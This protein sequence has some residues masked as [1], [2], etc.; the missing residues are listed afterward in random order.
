MLSRHP[1]AISLKRSFHMLIIFVLLSLVFAQAYADTTIHINPL[2]IQ[3]GTFMVPLRSLCDQ[4]G[5]AIAW[6]NDTQMAIVGN[7]VLETRYALGLGEDLVQLVDNRLYIA[8]DYFATQQELIYVIEQD[9][10]LAFYQLDQVNIDQMMQN[11]EHIASLP[12]PEKS[13]ELERVRKYLVEELTSMG[14]EVGLQP[15]ISPFIMALPPEHPL[16]NPNIDPEVG[17]NIIATKTAL[18]NLEE[19]PILL[20]TA[21]YNS[22]PNSPSANQKGSGVVGLLE[23]AKLMQVVSSNVELRMVFFDAELNTGLG[24]F[25]YV[26]SLTDSEVE[27]IIAV[28]D[29]NTL[30]SQAE[31]K[32]TTYTPDEKTVWLADLFTETEHIVSPSS[33]QSYFYSLAIPTIRVS[34][35]IITEGYYIS[36]RENDTLAIIDANKLQKAVIKSAEV[37]AF[38][39]SDASSSLRKI[40][41][42]V[43]D[44]N[45]VSERLNLNQRNQLDEWTRESIEEQVGFALTQIPTLPTIGN[46]NV[47]YAGYINWWEHSYLTI[48]NFSNNQ[49]LSTVS[50]ELSD[51]EQLMAILDENFERLSNPE[52]FIFSHLPNNTFMALPSTRETLTKTYWLDDLGYAYIIEEDADHATLWLST[53]NQ[54]L[55][56]EIDEG[57]A[58]LGNLSEYELQ[59]WLRISKILDMTGILSSINAVELVDDGLG[60]MDLALTSMIVP[61]AKDARMSLEQVITLSFDAKD[62][63]ETRGTAFTKE[64]VNEKAL[65]SWVAVLI[66]ALG[67]Q[68]ISVLRDDNEAIIMVLGS[69]YL[70]QSYLAQYMDTFGERW[71]EQYLEQEMAKESDIPLSQREEMNALVK[72]EPMRLASFVV[73]SLAEAGEYYLTG[74]EPIGESAS[75]L[76]QS[77]V[78]LYGAD[79]SKHLHD[80]FDQFPEFV[81]LKENFAE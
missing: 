28:I 40:G 71:V 60:G 31:G 25:G 46:V 54:K 38:L 3:D 27:R 73:A 62:L 52:S 42:T 17:Q 32:L 48:F 53:Y 68:E 74:K 2:E 24:S 36:N 14:Y 30:A 8:V 76:K 29:L 75:V 61:S 63:L 79:Y 20:L 69:E 44:K 70:P 55:R 1:F 33:A 51:T 26:N 23:I 16:Y 45:I 18:G 66:Q 49:K 12:R 77:F 47:S 57:G 67:Q 5:L 59:A 13:E 58:W 6:D 78:E 19:A 37:V 22:L 43:L 72:A 7:E 81:E 10:R 41:G 56:H 39:L 65:I 9:D 21:S 15:V 34:E 4:M 64:A 35:N 11:L 50:L 80:F